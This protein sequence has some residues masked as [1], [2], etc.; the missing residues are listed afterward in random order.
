MVEELMNR[1]WDMA[2][3]SGPDLEGFVKRAAQGD[4]GPVTPRDITAFLRQVEEITI[5]NI[6]TK[7]SEG[8]V[9]A[10]MKDQV[11][12]ETRAQISELVAKYGEA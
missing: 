12:E 2:M 10:R 1:Y 4:F 7:A 9:F 3:E 6:E 8:G 11:I 5:A